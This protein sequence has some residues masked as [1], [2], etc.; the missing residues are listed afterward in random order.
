MAKTW[1]GERLLDALEEF[2][3]SGRLARGRSYASEHRVKQWQIK[4]GVVQAKIRGNKNPYFG[5][6]K[7]PT[8]KTEVQMA[9]LT[10]AQWKKVIARLTQRASFI[11][12]LLV[13]EI[14]ENI[15]EVF[16]EFNTHF[17]PNSYKDFQVSCN[18]PDYAVP[19]KHIAG[20]CYRLAKVLDN[21]PLL[22]FE[23]RGL[24]PEKLHKELIKSPL[25]KILA[26]AQ[27]TGESELKPVAS[28]YTQPELK[29]IPEKIHLKQFWHGTIPLPK[30]LPPH[31]EA[32]IPAGLVKKGGDYPAFWHKQG[33]FIAVM[34]EFYLRMRKNNQKQM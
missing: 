3:D 31:Q 25:G 1:W 20:V 26:D 33:S 19:C 34:E 2:T 24:A 16:T 10:E 29:D 12:K 9:H 21:N 27:A 23:M 4:K 28:F 14:P 30:E 5:V 17:L 22:L 18:C 13:D 6:Y 8:Y 7:E 15:E 32:S 11:A